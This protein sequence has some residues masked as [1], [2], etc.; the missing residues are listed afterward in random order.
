MLETRAATLA[1]A[2]LMAS[3][4]KAMFAAM[5]AAG[6]AVLEIMRRNSEPWVKRMI[7]EGKYAGW[8]T[9]DSNRPAASAGLLILDW[10]PHPLDPTG[11]QRGYLLNVFVEPDYR[12]RGLARELVRLCLAEA[13]RRR[14]RVVTLHSSDAGRPIYEGFGFHPTNEMLFAE[15]REEGN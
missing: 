5:G 12:R 2:A 6:E 13:R 10:P 1:D 11:E 15:S 9:I 14:I 7:L 4:R 3:H 8:I